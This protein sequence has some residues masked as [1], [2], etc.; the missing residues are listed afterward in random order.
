MCETIEFLRANNDAQEK[1]QSWVENLK[2]GSITSETSG[3][4]K[5]ES[6]T[7]EFIETD[8]EFDSVSECGTKRRKLG[9]QLKLEKLNLICEWKNC[10]YSD[11]SMDSFIK[12]VANHV[13][14]L[15][16]K[17]T[18]E[19]EVYACLWLGCKYESPIDVD[20]MRHVNFHA[21]HT[22]L[23]C[24]GMNNRGRTK[25]PVR[26]QIILINMNLL[27][28]KIT[29]QKCRRDTD[30]KYILDTLPPHECH[31]ESCD[32]KSFNNYQLFIF[33]VLTHAEN[34]PRGNKV[35]GGIQCLWSECQGKYPS[36]YKLREHMR[37][38]TK[39]KL[40]A[41]PDCG[42]MFASNTKFY[43][44]CRRQIPMEGMQLFLVVVKLTF[45]KLYE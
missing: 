24:I 20:I 1:C 5:L 31:W 39:E 21:F 40:I 25:L 28:R 8:S 38:H 4:H 30:W 2:E 32:G 10:L 14:E 27:I 9:V 37:V 33:H 6:E 16:I 7:D 22:K 19:R 15:D 12:Q 29:F 23:K 45:M 43:D 41:C 11:K 13:T 35:A 26:K 34:N 36:L 44:H 42:A 17:I 18:S 3:K